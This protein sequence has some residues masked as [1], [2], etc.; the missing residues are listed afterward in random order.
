MV[1][2]VCPSTV[3]RLNK[4]HHSTE[5]HF[6]VKET[7][8]TDSPNGQ[9]VLQCPPS[10]LDGV[11]KHLRNERTGSSTSAKYWHYLFHFSF[12]PQDKMSYFQNGQAQ[13]DSKSIMGDQGSNT[14]TAESKSILRRN[15]FSPG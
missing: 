12:L 6:R 13:K 3:D 14:V 9:G 11:K 5:M 8:D 10:G 7:Q 15:F 2:C 4:N 1:V